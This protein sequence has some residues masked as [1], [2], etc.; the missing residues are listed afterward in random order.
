[1]FKDVGRE[2]F[3]MFSRPQDA[4]KNRLQMMSH[5]YWFICKMRI[6]KF[7]LHAENYFERANKQGQIDG[8]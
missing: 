7:M 4:S 6:Q 1:M 3:V 8:R 5:G 2:K